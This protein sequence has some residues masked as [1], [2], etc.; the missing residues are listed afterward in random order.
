MEQLPN[1]IEHIILDYKKEFEEFKGRQEDAVRHFFNIQA[2]AHFVKH[3]YGRLRGLTFEKM[4]DQIVAEAQFVLEIIMNEILTEH[5][6]QRLKFLEDEINQYMVD[7]FLVSIDPF[8]SV[9]ENTPEHYHT[10]HNVP[11]GIL[12][13]LW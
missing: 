4:V 9:Y 10:E 8:D 7:N 13:R 6:M 5:L 11:P 2:S 1:D 12:W 3:E